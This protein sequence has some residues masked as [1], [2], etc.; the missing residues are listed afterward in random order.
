MLAAAV[1]VVALRVTGI[2]G[3]PDLKWDPNLADLKVYLTAGRNW[4]NGEAIYSDDPYLAFLYPPLTAVVF[5]VASLVP[6]SVLAVAW[7][8]ANG[9]LVPFIL[10]RL[11][12]SCERALLWSVAVVI[13]VLPVRETIMLG[14][15]NLM[16][17]ALVVCAY[18]PASGTRHPL[19][20]G[21][22]VGIATAIKLTPGLFIAYFALERRF[23]LC[24]TAVVVVAVTIALGYAVAPRDSVVFWSRLLDGGT[25]LGNTA[26]YLYNQSFSG[27][28]LRVFGTGRWVHALALL[29][30]VVS[31]VV[32]TVVGAAWGRSGDR[33]AALSLVALGT[34]LASPVSWTNHYVWL[35]PLAVWAARRGQ[36][37]VAGLRHQARR[38][39]PVLVLAVVVAAVLVVWMSTCPFSYLPSGGDLELQY[40]AADKAVSGLT[41]VI[42]LVYVALMAVAARSRPRAVD[43]SKDQ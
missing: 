17:C 25:G 40:S 24:L 12:L 39:A 4:R 34:L 31:A 10:R 32:T 22:Q 16:L 18:F 11:G 13:L 38:S 1:V 26:V 23:R 27:A 29:M 30:T 20:A 41:V 37:I 6:F 43:D 8:T 19:R 9:L 33:L 15:V 14:Q 36:D 28:L 7:T 2:G 21:C 3:G 35:L 5:G 42:G